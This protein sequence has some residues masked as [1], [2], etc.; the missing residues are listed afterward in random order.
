MTRRVF[1]RRSL[2]LG[3]VLLLTGGRCGEEPV[4]WKLVWEDEFNG[5]AVDTSRWRFE[6]GDGCPDLCGW[7]NNELE[8][9][10]AENAAVAD[11]ILTVTARREPFEG[12]EYTSARL[13]T[14]DKADWVY[15]RFEARLRLPTGQGLWPAFW[16]LGVDIAEA[17]WPACG[18]IDI[19]EYRGQEPR[20]V[21]GALHGPGYSGGA[22]VGGRYTLPEGRFDEAFHTFAVEWEGD[23]ITWLVDDTRYRSVAR[24]DLPA[25]ARWVFDHPF[26][27]ILNLAVGGNFVGPPGAAT[28]FPQSLRVDWVR[29]Y[30]AEP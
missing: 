12:R 24:R 26:F 13:I 17:G 10:R 6:T 21:T 18:E 7:G 22:S 29:V 11:G 5:T 27:L 4:E 30:Q 9:Y 25:N 3:L 2:A 23:R 16:L 20:T 15:G 8:Y 28:T 1:R 14:L 19:M